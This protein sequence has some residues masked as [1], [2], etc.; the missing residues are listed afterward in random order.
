MTH[1]WQY[2][3]IRNV[4]VFTSTGK[5][6]Y[7]RPKYTFSKKECL[8]KGI[9]SFL[10]YHHNCV[11]FVFPKCREATVQK[12][13]GGTTDPIMVMGKLRADKDNFRPK[14]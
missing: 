3:Y 4:P 1:F 11:L 12:H 7:L 6:Q 9:K 10:I 5:F 13:V 8:T 14:M 2:W